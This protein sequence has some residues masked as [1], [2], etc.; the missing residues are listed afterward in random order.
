MDYLAPGIFT[1]VQPA[2]REALAKLAGISFNRSR[3]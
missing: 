3:F 1:I 2:G